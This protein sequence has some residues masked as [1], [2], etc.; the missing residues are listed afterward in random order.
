MKNDAR[1][2]LNKKKLKNQ[3]GNRPVEIQRGG[4]PKAPFD[5]RK[6]LN[7]KRAKNVVP[8]KQIVR[9]THN[10]FNKSAKGIFTKAFSAASKASLDI[11]N[12]LG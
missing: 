4:G 1:F 10:K 11:Y 8:K 9:G 3:S 7:N 6:I 2:L 12:L 5:A